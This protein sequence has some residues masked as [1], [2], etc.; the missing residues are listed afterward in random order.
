MG[1]ALVAH[2][3]DDFVGGGVEY[4][5]QRD[6]QFHHA[7]ARRQVAAHGGELFEDEG[8]DLPRE[9]LHFLHAEALE[10]GRAADRFE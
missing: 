6:G 10:V 3:P 9:L 2:V 8:A 7:Q 1:I 4:G 5:V